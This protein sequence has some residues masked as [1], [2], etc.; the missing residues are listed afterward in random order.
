MLGPVLE[1][2]QNDFHDPLIDRVFPILY[3]R[4]RIPLPPQEIAG[5]DMKVD[6]ISLLAMAQKRERLKA[7]NE[8]ARF[9]AALSAFAPEA[10]DKFDSDRAVD[11][12]AEITGIPPAIIRSGDQVAVLRRKR[13]MK[14]DA[15]QKAEDFSRALKDGT[16]AAK[17]LSQTD[18]DSLN[19]LTQR[20]KLFKTGRDGVV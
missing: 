10:R 9:V 1:R 15:R 6:Y 14:Q 7:I 2:Q 18:V 19:R 3:R 4:G 17:A 16:S 20:S 5:M 8:T 11:Q 13:A 12:V